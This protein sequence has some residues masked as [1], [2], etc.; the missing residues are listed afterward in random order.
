MIVMTNLCKCGCGTEILTKDKWGN[1]PR[2]VNGHQNR[3]LIKLKECECGCGQ[4][5]P[6]AKTDKPFKYAKK[7]YIKGH[8]NKGRPPNKG[9]FGYG[10]SSKG[11]ISPKKEKFVPEVSLRRLFQWSEKPSKDYLNLSLSNNATSR[12]ALFAVRQFFLQRDAPLCNCG[13]GQKVNFS[14]GKYYRFIAGHQKIGMPAWNKG[15]SSW[16]SDKNNIFRKT[17]VEHPNHGVKWSDETIEKRTETRRKNDGYRAWNKERH[18]P[19]SS[20]IRWLWMLEPKICKCGCNQPIPYRENYGSLS[21]ID[22]HPHKPWNRGKHGHLSEKSIEKLREARLKRV[23]PLQRTSIELKIEELLI[24]E[25]IPFEAQKRILSITQPDFFLK[26]NICIYADGD[27]WHGNPQYYPP[28]SLNLLSAEIIML[29]RELFHNSHT[30]C[31]SA[32]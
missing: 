12:R 23:L 20:F 27:Y 18:D 28:L 25:R 5:L 30:G 31:F 15:T 2:F 32:S 14:H 1:R 9:S 21:Y 19:N 13:C 3:K 26:P 17:G 24:E 29:I 22:D 10:R 7:R 8:F 11:Q 4:V 6:V 16:N